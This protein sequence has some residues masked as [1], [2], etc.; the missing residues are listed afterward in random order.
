MP[1]NDLTAAILTSLAALTALSAVAQTAPTAKASIPV[2]IAVDKPVT[3]V[4]KGPL[5]SAKTIKELLEADDAIALSKERKAMAIELKR[6]EKDVPN[7]TDEVEQAAIAK[8]ADEQTRQAGAQAKK[9]LGSTIVLSGVMGARGERVVTAS[10]AGKEVRLAEGGSA[11][12]SGWKLLQINGACATFERSKDNQAER[13]A[14]STSPKVLAK[15]TL[16][17]QTKTACFTQQ[18][19]PITPEQAI[20]TGTGGPIPLPIPF[21]IPSPPRAPQGGGPLVAN[22]INPGFP[23]AETSRIGTTTPSYIQK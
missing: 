11:V 8:K 3:N 21:G 20:F 14:G 16:A 23:S 13:A 7:V 10:I 22:A 19:N 6:F 15:T 5:S 4:S 2:V 9:I 1:R 17:V 18:T 12:T